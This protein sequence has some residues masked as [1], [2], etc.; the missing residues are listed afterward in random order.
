MKLFICAINGWNPYSEEIKSI[1][2][3]YWLIAFRVHNF[4]QYE[5]WNSQLKPLG[6]FIASIVSPENY[7]EWKK[8]T[9]QK[10]INKEQGLPDQ[11]NLGDRHIAKA[12]T[13]FDPVKGLVHSDTGEILVSK[14]DMQKRLNIEGIA[15]SL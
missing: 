9:T 15:Y 14:E 8:Y 10:E 6:E 5:N 12:N 11:V 7:A 1:P 2:S 4:K 3:Y 13:Y